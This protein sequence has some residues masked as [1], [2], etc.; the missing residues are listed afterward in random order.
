MPRLRPFIAC[1]FAA[2]IITCRA[3]AVDWPAGFTVP[4]STLSPD[5]RYGVLVPDSDHYDEARPQNKVVE[6][7][8]GRVLALIQAETGM[9]QMNHGGIVPQWSADSQWLLWKVDGK[10][11]PRALVLVKIAEGKVAWQ[12]NI[13]QQAQQAALARARTAEPKAYA[14]AKEYNKGNG[15]AYPDGFTIGVTTPVD[16]GKPVA[17]PLTVHADLSS[18]PKAIEGFPKAA[19]LDATLDAVVTADG[20]FVVKKFSASR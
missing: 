4:A 1:V 12:T 13:L 19:T 9:E 2:I 11:S 10:W 17:V 3:A 16:D 7:A 18:N 15:S 5:G 8:A 20:K 14:A 6:V